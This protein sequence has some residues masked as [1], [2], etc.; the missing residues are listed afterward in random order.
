MA[1]ENVARTV[2]SAPRRN[3]VGNVALTE[4]PQRF[5]RET[6]NPR[7]PVEERS[8]KVKNNQFYGSISDTVLTRSAFI[9]FNTR[10][11]HLPH[12]FVL[13]ANDAEGDGAQRNY[14]NHFHSACYLQ[15]SGNTPRVSGLGCRKTGGSKTRGDSSGR[16]A[17]G[18]GKA[19]PCKALTPR[20]SRPCCLDF[21]IAFHVFTWFLKKWPAHSAGRKETVVTPEVWDLL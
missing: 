2:A 21:V 1:L 17:R 8:V 3:R 10:A 5:T 20:K 6:R 18:P 11:L 13:L 4:Q 9:P 14:D 12:G 7:R 15:L 19:A 16:A